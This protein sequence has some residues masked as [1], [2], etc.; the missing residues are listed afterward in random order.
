MAHYWIGP[1][2]DAWCDYMSGV[3]YRPPFNAIDAGATVNFAER[4]QPPSWKHWFGTDIV[5]RDVLS[6]V[7]VGA[8]ISMIIAACVIV[9]AVLIGRLDRRLEVR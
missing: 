7:I 4:L 6:R 5:G 9:L 1:D 8:R 3:Q 2:S